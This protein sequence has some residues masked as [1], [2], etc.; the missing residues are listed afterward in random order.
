MQTEN[1]PDQLKQEP[2]TFFN[3]K[4]RPAPFDINKYAMPYNPSRMNHI[5]AY[6]A[7]VDPN[8]TIKEPRPRK[9]RRLDVSPLP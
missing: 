4:T 9:V 3:I 1:T 5:D 2:P 7:I 8:Q 6:N